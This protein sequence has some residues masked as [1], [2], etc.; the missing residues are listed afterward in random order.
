MLNCRSIFIAGLTI[1]SLSAC[2]DDPAAE[3]DNRQG[4]DT[5]SENTGG[6][7][8]G[9]ASDELSSFLPTLKN[10]K[11]AGARDWIGQ[12]DSGSIVSMLSSTSLGSSPSKVKATRMVATVLR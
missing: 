1:I 5:S 10:S 11:F 4:R 7:S 8:S 9:G 12:C 6:L 3:V 2:K